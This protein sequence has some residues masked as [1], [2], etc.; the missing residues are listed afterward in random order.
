MND[1]FDVLVVGGG[2]HGVGVAQAAA[3][4]G[5]RVL[6][7][8]QT[9][10][11]AGTSSRSSKLVHGGLRYLES[12]DLRLVRESLAERETLLAIAPDLVT[13]QAFHIP[14]YAQSRRQPW[15]VAAGLAL[16]RLLARAHGE[17]V[18]VPRSGWDQLDG[19]ATNGL[20]AVYRYY[21]AQTDDLALTR[22]VAHS[23]EHYGA[24]IRVGARFLGAERNARGY[25]V[26]YALQGTV[27]N[28]QTRTLVNAAGPWIGQVLGR[29]LPGPPRLP[30]DLVQGAHI[31]TPGRLSGG[32]YYVEAPA[33][34]RPVFIM[35][36]RD[37][38]LTGTTE[39]LYAGDPGQ[40]AVLPQEIGY[41]QEVLAAYFPQRDR[42]PQAA[43]A[44]LRVLPRAEGGLGRRPR[45]VILLADA[46]DPRLITIIGGKLTGYRLTAARVLARLAAALPERPPQAD[47]RFLPLTPASPAA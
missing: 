36:W 6:L 22:A 17:F 4:R 11:G 3:V 8:E 35:P 2:I 46:P 38:V 33:D 31:V 32:A 13:R 25:E 21:D 9:R 44:G 37:G 12:G 24:D 10:L 47:T 42:T 1:L 16:Y 5:H 19:L 34:R 27:A 15:Q 30:F 7:L 40:V 26:R 28:C 20:R 39:T 23:A 14:L 18:R 43:F 41:L 45:E 29:I